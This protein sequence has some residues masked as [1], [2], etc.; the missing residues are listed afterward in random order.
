MF[1]YFSIVILLAIIS[2][3]RSEVSDKSNC[4]IH[5]GQYRYEYLYSQDDNEMVDTADRNMVKLMTLGKVNDF[6]NLRW[7]LIETK[8][9]SGQFYL[10]S[11]YFGDYLCA[12]FMFGD[13]FRMRR[14]VIRHKLN[15]N[16]KRLDNCKWM[17]KHIDSK[18]SN[19]TYLITNVFFEEPLYAATYFYQKGVYLWHKKNVNSKKFQWIIDCKTGQHLWI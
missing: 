17:I 15:P 1:K 10:K 9:Q 11:S 3:L 6:N 2:R 18:T 12:T 16:A 5:N 7:S 13:I 14:K 8:N 19:N 4:L